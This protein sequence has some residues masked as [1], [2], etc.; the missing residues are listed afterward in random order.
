MYSL[1]ISYIFVKFTWTPRISLY[2]TNPSSS[3]QSPS[4]YDAFCFVF[5]LLPTELN[6]AY[7]LGH[8]C[9]QWLPVPSAAINHCQLSRKQ[10]GP[11]KYLR[12]KTECWRVQF[13]AGTFQETS[14]ESGTGYLKSR[15]NPCILSIW[16]SQGFFVCSSSHQPPTISI[17][18]SL[19]CVSLYKDT[20]HNPINNAHFSNRITFT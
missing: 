14:L 5:V 3:Q 8:V 20:S 18:L 6:Q 16:E 13:C 7:L 15:P 1:E 10:L 11:K 19:W 17:A 9:R 2:P 4:H 12:S